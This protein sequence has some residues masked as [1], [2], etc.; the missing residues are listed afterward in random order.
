MGKRKK[1]GKTPSGGRIPTPAC[2]LA[3]NDSQNR[4]SR[5]GWEPEF[6]VR[7]RISKRPNTDHFTGDIQAT[8]TTRLIEALAVM[9]QKAAALI[10]APLGEVYSVVA[11]VLFAD[12]DGMEDVEE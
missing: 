11:T 9:M 3:R 8:D 4:K 2:E 7:L 6:E 5:K 1:H 12:R 10:G